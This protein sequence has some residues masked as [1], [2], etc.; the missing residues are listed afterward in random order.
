MQIACCGMD[1]DECNALI[2][3]RED[4]HALRTATAQA[5]S[6]QYNH[7]F[8]PEDIQCTG[9]RSEGAKIVHCEVCPVRKCCIERGVAHCGQCRDFPCETLEEF[10]KI[11]PDGG[12][13]NRNRLRDSGRAPDEKP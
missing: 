2:A 3:T 1:C 11:F 7:P 4:D 5:W 6:K 12:A 13:E 10:F 9:C 8:R